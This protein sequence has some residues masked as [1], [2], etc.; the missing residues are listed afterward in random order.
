VEVIPNAVELQEETEVAHDR[1]VLFIGSFAYE[2]NIVAADYLVTE[3][4]PRVL[5]AVPDALLLIAGAKPERIPGYSRNPPGVKFLGFVDDL[6]KLY[7][8]VM[9]VACPVFSGGGTRVKILEAAAFGRPVVST[10][11]GAEGLG[12]REGSEILLRDDPRAFADECIRLL[13]D[14]E[15]VIKIGRAGRSAVN[16]QYDRNEV[17]RRIR[18]CVGDR[19]AAST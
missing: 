1:R 11:I 7:E 3:I 16:K 6:K 14:R 19:R 18:Q 13:L 10:T 9:V 8:E 12:L 5:S 15:T 17:V 2:P 4:W